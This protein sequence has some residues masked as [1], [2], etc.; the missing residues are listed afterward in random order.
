MKYANYVCL[1]IALSSL[2]VNADQTY[3]R[4]PIEIAK[5]TQAPIING[6]ITASEWRDAAVIEQFVE[7]RPNLGDTPLYPI[8]AWVAYDESYFYV[9]A[10]ISQ[11]Q[12]SITDRVLTQ[13][14]NIWN[15]DYFGIT[16]DTNFDKRDAYLFHVSPSGVREDGLIDGTQYIG[17]W[18]TIWY[19]KN[20]RT[21]N[22]WSVEMAIPMQ[23][24]SFD[25]SKSDW[26]LQLRHKL[27]K[28]YKQIYWN[29]NDPSNWGWT[30]PQVGKITNIHGLTQGKGVEIKTGLS[31]KDNQES[32]KW[33][34]SLD[35]FYKFSPNITGVL[36][37]NTDFSGTDVDEVDINMTRFSQFFEEKRDFFLQDSQVFSFGDFSNYDYNGMPFYSRRIGQ[38]PQSGVLDIDWGTKFT[39]KV[40]GTS[41]G[42]LSV[43]Q[44]KDGS[45]DDT[46]QLSVA[47][48]KQ[49]LGQHHQVGAIITDGSADGGDNSGLF[50]VD[51]R[52]ENSIFGDQQIR[53]YAWYQETEKQHHDDDTIAYGAQITLPNDKIYASAIYR[54]LGE[55]FNPALGFVNRNGINYYEW[56]SHLR[57]RP[58]TGFLSNYINYYQVNY[59]YFQRNDVDNNWLSKM[60]T[61][62]PMRIQMKDSSV[63]QIQYDAR[64]ERLKNRYAMGRRIGFAAKDYHFDQWSV[65]YQTSTN[66]SVFGNIKLTTGEFYD[67]DRQEVLA[68]LNYKPNKHVMLQLSRN[69]HYYAQSVLS[70][71]MYSTRLKANISFNEEWSWNTMIQHNTRSDN[72]SIFSRLRYQ[73]APDELYQVSINKGYDLED[74]WHQRQSYFDEKTI[75]VNYINRW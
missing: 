38:G 20:Q 17:Q 27:S 32:S 14:D 35:A 6:N 75:K 15:E 42:V 10:E 59:N 63:F 47:R 12:Q 26:G 37:L 44:E 39:G 11:P 24:L 71:N 58:K 34:P 31:F 7:F 53:A 54:Y 45:V 13:G 72:L 61:I 22:G 30:A 62:R 2:S 19:A 52:Y 43:N 64:T 56:V 60:Y 48:V 41:F 65:F 1:A 4:A 29:V 50:G 5:L 21:Q 33:T 67:S 18:S 23:S 16:L 3:Q 68:E 70:E 46:T 73:S 40:D 8:K 69:H 49:Q 74:G 66:Q 36:T 25:P 51:Y 28:P 57:H 55:D 9:A